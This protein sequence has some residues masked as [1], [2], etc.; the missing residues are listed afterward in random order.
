M[1]ESEQ[2]RFQHLL[3][4]TFNNNLKEL[5]DTVENMLNLLII[6]KKQIK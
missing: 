1:D 6:K 3:K 4:H 5:N 2:Q